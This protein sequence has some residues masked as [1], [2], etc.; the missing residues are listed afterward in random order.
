MRM[1]VVHIY[2]LRMLALQSTRAVALTFLVGFSLHC[3]DDSAASPSDASSGDGSTGSPSAS[4]GTGSIADSGSSDGPGADTTMGDA[5][6]E[7]VSIELEVGPFTFDARAAGPEDGELVMLLHGFPQTSYEWRAQLLALGEAGY[8]AV[9]PDQRGYSPGARP[10]EIDDY[11]SD[12]LVGDVLA[13][14]DELGADAFHLVGHDWG[15]AV[16]WTVA[17]QYPERIT[18]LSTFS[19]PHPDAFDAQLADMMSCQ[20]A[21]SAYFDFFVSPGAEA[22][23]LANDAMALRD[24]YEGLEPDAIEEYL[25]QLGSE[26][27]LGAALNWYRANIENRRFTTGPFGSVTVPTMYVWSDGDAAV[28]QEG[29]DTTGDFVSGPYRYEVISGIGHWIPELAADTVSE[30]LLEHLATG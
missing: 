4:D 12:L 20:Y 23:L 21:A 17:A 8:R 30:L 24:V 27:A 28:C 1:A 29:A 25:G 11:E 9:A 19:I 22:M 13:M 6:V 26:A 14:A 2:M 10:P 16:A 18:T 3:G 7:I 5:P 15:A